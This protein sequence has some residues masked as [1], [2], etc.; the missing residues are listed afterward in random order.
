MKIK[1]DFKLDLLMNSKIIDHLTYSFL[2]KQLKPKKNYYSLFNHQ[3]TFSD[4]KIYR[5]FN[6]HNY[7][8]MIVLIS[9]IS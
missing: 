1:S 2:K 3:C 9:S 4:S 6:Y 5:L 8:F 7:Q